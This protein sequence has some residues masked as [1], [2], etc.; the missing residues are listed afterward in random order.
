MNER[1]PGVRVPSAFISALEEAGDDAASV[2]LDLAVE[3]I[4]HVRA[5]RGVAGIHLTGIAHADV[6]RAVVERAALFPR[7]TGAF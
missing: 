1:L 4:Q 5:I 7:P 3:V 6:V 2:G